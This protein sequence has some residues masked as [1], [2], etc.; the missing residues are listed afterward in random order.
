MKFQQTVTMD[1]KR[2]VSSDDYTFYVLLQVFAKGMAP[3][4]GKPPTLAALRDGVQA[5]INFLY[6]NSAKWCPHLSSA[7]LAN[8][9]RDPTEYA[10]IVTVV[11]DQVI[12]RDTLE[13]IATELKIR[14]VV[15]GGPQRTS[16]GRRRRRATGQSFYQA[17]KQRLGL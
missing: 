14:P 6:A 7:G 9:A 16:T 10:E 13:H 3:Y 11:T 5:M 4:A 15:C 12:E 8:L 2:F 1:W 17:L